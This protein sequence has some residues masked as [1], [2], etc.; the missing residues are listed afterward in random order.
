MNTNKI[1]K[2][3][4]LASVTALATMVITIPAPLAGYVNMGDAFVL[5][6]GVILGPLYGGLSAGIGSFIADMFTYPV[7]AVATFVIKFLMGFV[8]GSMCK[9]HKTIKHKFL[10]FCIA[11]IIMIVGYMLYGMLIFGETLTAAIATVPGNCVQAV[12]GI[13]LGMLLSKIK[14]I[15]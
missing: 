13:T 11:E 4:I 2:C 15:K 10:S 3:G 1:V 7:Y 6:S 8:C 9:K 14:V 5:L 12:V